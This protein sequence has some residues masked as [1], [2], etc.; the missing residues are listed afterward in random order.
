MLRITH[1]FL[2][3]ILVIPL[4]TWAQIPDTQ[5]LRCHSQSNLAKTM[6]GK[7]TSLYVN[8]D[9]LK[10]SV[11]GEFR[12]LSC[13]LDLARENQYPHLLPPKPVDCASCHSAEG[14]EMAVS[15]HWHLT[16]AD[17]TDAMTC[18][19]C[20]GDHVIKPAAGSDSPTNRRNIGKLCLACHAD[21]EVVI[22]S[23]VKVSAYERSVHGLEVFV[24]GDTVAANCV[25]CHGNHKVLPANNPASPVYKH[26]V[27][28][29]CGQCHKEARINYLNSIH[30]QAMTKGILEAPVCTDCHGEHTIQTPDSSLSSIS[31]SNVP[32]TCG[33]CHE[34][35]ILTEKYG[36]ASERFST[37]QSSYHGV[38]N[39]YGRTVV[40][41]CASC[42][43]FHEIL[44]PSDPASTVHPANLAATCGH[45]HP[46]A[47]ANFAKGKM[48]VQATLQNSPGVF[49]VRRFYY[50]FIG[51]L[52]VLFI[53]YMILDYSGFI[54]RRRERRS[55]K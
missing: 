31:P 55:S 50:L 53:L 3:P 25:D 28:Q 10:A 1:Y 44:P 45:C 26:T 9:S 14:Q 29:T 46:D 38:A 35:V 33:H 21:Q 7:T 23:G 41:N 4:L 17:R 19:S 39:Q 5:C 43:G 11:H 40:A 20:H 37:Y 51:G 30:G 48:H 49:F 12:C 8:V 27:P 32:K 47:S 34:N 15:S 54:R 36:I 2:V 52:M 24:K 16:Q 13:H 22:G 6:N 42:H 18:A